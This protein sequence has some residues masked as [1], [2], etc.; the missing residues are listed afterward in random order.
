MNTRAKLL[1]TY[2]PLSREVTEASGDTEKETVVV[3]EVAGLED[4]IVG[5]GGCMHLGQDLLGKSLG[6]PRFE[7]VRSGISLDIREPHALTD[8]W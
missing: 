2:L 8:R 7:S 5:L 1:Y 3:S 4:G 6:N